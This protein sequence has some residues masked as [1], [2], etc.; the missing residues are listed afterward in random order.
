MKAAPSRDS[1]GQGAPTILVVDDNP[2]N[3]LVAEGRLGAAGYRVLL[4]QNG[5]EALS[6]FASERCDLVLLLD[7]LTTTAPRFTC[8]CPRPEA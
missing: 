2:Q 3:R 4:A 1:A 8:S 6:M 5:A 7:V